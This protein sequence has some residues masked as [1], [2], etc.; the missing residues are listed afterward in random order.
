MVD[1]EIEKGAR[2]K[3]Q[4]VRTWNG[5]YLDVRRKQTKPT[6]MQE[7]LKD[8]LLPLYETLLKKINFSKD[9]Y[10]FCMQWG[11]RFPIEENT[12]ILFVGKATNGWITNSREIEI[13]FGTSE[14]RIFAR[15]DQMKWVNNL[16]NNKKG[17][18]TRTSAFWR[19]TKQISQLEYGDNEWYSKIAWSNLYKI[20]GEVGNPTQ[21][22]KN[23]QQD[24]CKKILEEEIRILKPRY[25]IFL[26]S[27]WEKNFIKHIINDLSIHDK[28]NTTWGNG[29][30]TNGY[31]IN[32]VIY[33]TT[34][35]P[36]GKNEKK[37]VQA[38]RETMTNFEKIKIASP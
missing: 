26:T 13:L 6:N 14:S 7:R 36:Q 23:Q 17:Y 38:I 4:G 2:S 35:H 8:T 21:R 10:S 3:E 11:S 31:L 20:S 24:L 34:R 27:G 32:D 1:I 15:G 22:L 28:V 37:H 19:L 12:G 18:N 30:I 9:I 16:E 25:V 5:L 29:F 33:I